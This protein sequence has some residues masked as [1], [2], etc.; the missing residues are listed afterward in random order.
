VQEKLRAK[1]FK[2]GFFNH[3]RLKDL[4]KIGVSTKLEEVPDDPNLLES[5]TSAIV[6]LWKLCTEQRESDNPKLE[7]VKHVTIKD[8]VFNPAFQKAKE[9]KQLELKEGGEKKEGNLKLPEFL[10][11]VKGTTRIVCV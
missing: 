1:T 3:F 2:H 6:S 4:V 11:L 8:A 9:D 10:Y 7:Y 5:K